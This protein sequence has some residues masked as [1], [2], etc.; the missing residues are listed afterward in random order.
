MPSE[1]AHVASEEPA[2]GAG[3]GYAAHTAATPAE[4]GKAPAPGPF[5]ECARVGDLD[6]A[7]TAGPAPFQRDAYGEVRFG[8]DS[9]S[10]PP[11]PVARGFPVAAAVSPPSSLSVS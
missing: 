5:P 11:L 10:L 7:R 9:A 2:P 1:R 4:G 8:L 3:A 6:Q